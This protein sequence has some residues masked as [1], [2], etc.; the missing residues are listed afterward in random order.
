[1]LFKIKLIL[2]IKPIKR[3]NKIIDKKYINCSRKI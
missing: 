3:Y 2:E 1:M